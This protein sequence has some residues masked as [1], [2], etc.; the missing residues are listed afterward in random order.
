MSSCPRTWYVFLFV[1][2]VP[3]VPQKGFD[4]F[5]LKVLHIPYLVNSLIFYFMCAILN[6]IYSWSRS[7]NWSRFVYKEAMDICKLIL[8]LANFLSCLV[9]YNIF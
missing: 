8:C 2:V 4:V 9:I 3:C 5:F 7:P 1:Q 6:R